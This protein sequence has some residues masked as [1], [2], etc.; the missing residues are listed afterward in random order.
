[1]ERCQQ[2]HYDSRYRQTMYRLKIEEKEVMVNLITG[3]SDSVRTATK[4]QKLTILLAYVGLYILV[5]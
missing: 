3:E 2:L 4:Q 5:W 1:M